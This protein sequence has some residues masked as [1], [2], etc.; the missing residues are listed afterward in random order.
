MS[1][2]PPPFLQ[3]RL[4]TFFSPLCKPC[5]LQGPQQPAAVSFLQIRVGFRPETRTSREVNLV[6]C[7]S[8]FLSPLPVPSLRF[9]RAPQILCLA[10]TCSLSRLGPSGQKEGTSILLESWRGT[11]TF[12][13]KPLCTTEDRPV[14]IL[15]D[16]PGAGSLAAGS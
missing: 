6:L 3:P 13:K 15:R 12:L 5:V 1:S 10:V 14:Y 11:P 8:R 4:L 9:L 2:L 16:R 7:P